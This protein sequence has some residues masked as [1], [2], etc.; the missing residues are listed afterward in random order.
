MRAKKSRLALAATVATLVAA[1][2]LIA[3]PGWGADPIGGLEAGTRQCEQ[4]NYGTCP[5]S[6]MQT[7]VPSSCSGTACTLDCGGPGSCRTPPSR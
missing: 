1:V 5:G 6:C 2:A 7:C 4:Y 3:L